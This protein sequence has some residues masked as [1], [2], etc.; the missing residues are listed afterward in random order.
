MST[1]NRSKIVLKTSFPLI[2]WD[3]IAPQAVV[4]CGFF[5]KKL[6]CQLYLLIVDLH[7]LIILENTITLQGFDKGKQLSWSIVIIVLL[8]V[9]NH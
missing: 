9:H 3:N 5:S 8:L 6:K 1:R 4:E 7:Y 2:N